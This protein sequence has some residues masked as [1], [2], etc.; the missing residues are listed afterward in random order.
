VNGES[1][2]GEVSEDLWSHA[3]S[4][5]RDR[6]GKDLNWKKKNEELVVI[7]PR[8]K[9]KEVLK[10]RRKGR[11]G[12]D[13]FRSHGRGGRGWEERGQGSKRRW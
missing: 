12:D 7:D 8:E 9:Q 4:F 6:L 3:L 11:G 13:R 5:E 2:G 10:E 1:E